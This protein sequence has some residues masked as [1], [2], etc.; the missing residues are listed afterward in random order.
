MTFAIGESPVGE[1]HIGELP[2]THI[3]PTRHDMERNVKKEICFYHHQ[4]H[5]KMI[6]I[7][8]SNESSFFLQK[9]IFNIDENVSKL[10]T[11]KNS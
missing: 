8:Q 7:Q 3:Y 6:D 11:I 4:Q 10:F 2:A 5:L 9:Y 1:S